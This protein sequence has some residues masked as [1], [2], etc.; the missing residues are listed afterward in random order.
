VALRCFRVVCHTCSSVT[1]SKDY[2]HGNLAAAVNISLVVTS[3][4]VLLRS[5]RAL[6]TS[7]IVT[8]SHIACYQSSSIAARCRRSSAASSAAASRLLIHA[9]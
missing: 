7:S 3:A 6:S 8:R 9:S 1:D 4:A 5:T 2:D